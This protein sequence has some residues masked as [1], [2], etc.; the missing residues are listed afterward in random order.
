[1]NS[2]VKRKN[3]KVLKKIEVFI[4][5]FPSS[6]AAAGKAG[7][8]SPLRGGSGAGQQPVQVV[9]KDSPII[10]AQVIFQFTQITYQ[11][12]VNDLRSHRQGEGISLLGEL[13]S[14]ETEIVP[15]YPRS[16]PK[17][18]FT[19]ILSFVDQREVEADTPSTKDQTRDL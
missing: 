13:V 10:L 15:F 9:I 5:C 7:G 12:I 6:G 4:F 17:L 19:D 18:R 3:S 16:M 14:V 8:G 2:K 11:C 1:M